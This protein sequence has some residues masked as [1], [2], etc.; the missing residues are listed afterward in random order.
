MRIPLMT[1]VL[2]S[3]LILA[4]AASAQESIR[5]GQTIRGA[6]TAKDPTIGDGTHYR[7]YVVQTQADRVYTV[8]M[9]SANFDTFLAAGPGSACEE[10]RLSND[11]GPDMDTH[12]QLRFRSSGGP[13]AIRTNTLSEGETGDYQ[14]AVS[15]GERIQPT[16]NIETISVGET[17]DGTLEVSDRM[18]DDG[19]YYDC[20]A[21]NIESGATIN[22]R[23]D[24][25]DFDAY[26]A[27]HQG[28]RCEGELL[29]RDDDSGGGTSALISQAMTPGAYSFRANS[30]N[31]GQE[32]AYSVTVSRRR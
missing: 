9:T 18:A 11:D 21:L 27:L 7:C 22:I 5:P 4:G 24:S 29:A 20:Y 32:G 8:T 17:V 25:S 28:G 6:F 10:L 16:T 30:L 13:W 2:G 14:L 23:Q 15:Q 1:T 26:L 12:S 31:M 19:S 3:A